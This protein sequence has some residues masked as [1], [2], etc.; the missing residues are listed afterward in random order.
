MLLERAVRRSGWDFSLCYELSNL[1]CGGSCGGHTGIW[2]EAVVCHL[3]LSKASISGIVA[4]F[5]TDEIQQIKRIQI[6]AMAVL[7]QCR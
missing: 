1:S 7:Q 6:P 5:Y 3:S 2:S 4:E